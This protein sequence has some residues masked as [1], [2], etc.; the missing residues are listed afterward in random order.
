M[1]KLLA[2]LLLS[3]LLL[4]GMSVS[5]ENFDWVEDIAPGETKVVT[6]PQPE[7]EIDEGWVYFNQTFI[8]NPETSGTYRFLVSYEEDA[9]NPYEIY[10]GVAAFNYVEDG[11]EYVGGEY[12]ELENGCEF[13]AVAGQLHELGFQYGTHDGRYP[14]FTFHVE[15]V[16]GSEMPQMNLGTNPPVELGAEQGLFFSFTPEKTGY[17]TLDVAFETSGG[18]YMEAESLEPIP[19]EICYYLEA[20]VPYL[21]VVM[22]WDIQ[23]VVVTLEYLESL[24][25]SDVVP[26]PI[27]LGERKLV[28]VPPDETAEVEKFL[29]YSFVAE[30]SGHYRLMVSAA[31]ELLDYPM[32]VLQSEQPSWELDNGLAFY[33]EAGEVCDLSFYIYGVYPQGAE[34]ALQVE[35]AF[36]PDSV[37]LVPGVAQELKLWDGKTVDFSFTP[38]ESGY[39]TLDVEALG[40][41]SYSLYGFVDEEYKGV[42]CY[43]LSAGTTYTGDV[44]GGDTQ[45]CTLRLELLEAVELEIPETGDESIALLSGLLILATVGMVCLITKRKMI[46]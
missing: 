43:Y 40:S 30:Q 14:T 25:G 15:F 45:V 7:G 17:Y 37:V 39:Y 10:M 26:E 3:F 8:F 22:N 44:T 36:Q 46:G 4:G 23:S 41:I 42:E 20:G 18:Y 12:L 34:Y 24:P 21:G 11:I 35:E 13:E 31:Q 2:L 5:A 33:A 29:R 16:S 27:A 6:I 19:G 38:E 28:S 9:E 32:F 1:K